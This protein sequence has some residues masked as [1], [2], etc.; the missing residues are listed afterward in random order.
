MSNARRSS[1]RRNGRKTL[2]VVIPAIL[3]ATVLSSCAGY[4]VEIVTPDIVEYED[5]VLKEAK[6]E[7]DSL[8]PPCPRDAV[9]GGCSAINRMIKDYQFMRDQTRRLNDL[10]IQRQTGEPLQPE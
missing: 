2:R 8:G 6:R 3:S 1:M 9:F 5:V 7:Y 4:G 10:V